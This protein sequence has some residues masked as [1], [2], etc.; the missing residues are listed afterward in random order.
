M[1]GGLN[2]TNIEVTLESAHCR[3]SDAEIQSPQAQDACTTGLQAEDKA[4][5]ILCQEQNFKHARPMS[6]S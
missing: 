5:M 4:C 2:L 6:K 1:S 3:F